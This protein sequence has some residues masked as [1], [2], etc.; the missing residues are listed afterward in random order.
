MLDFCPFDFKK[1]D[2]ENLA[3]ELTFPNNWDWERVKTKTIVGEEKLFFINENDHRRDKHF[4]EDSTNTQIILLENGKRGGKNGFKIFCEFLEYKKEKMKKG[5]SPENGT[6]SS[7][8]ESMDMENTGGYRDF[9]GANASNFQAEE[10]FKSDGPVLLEHVKINGIDTFVDED[11]DEVMYAMPCCP[12][13]HNRLP[14]GWD[15]AED[16]GAVSLMAKTGGG[17]TTLL[18]SMMHNH[19]AAFRNPGSVN[20]KKIYITSAHRENDPTDTYYS[21]MYNLAEK[22]CQDYGDCPDPTQKA[23][24]IPPVFLNVQYNGHTMIIGIYD[25]AGEN[26]ELP[27][28]QNNTQLKMLLDKMFAD[29]YLFD[30]EDMNI[31]LPKEK[32]EIRRKNFEDCRMLDISQQGL[33]QKENSQREITARELLFEQQEVKEA[34]KKVMRG[35]RIYDNNHGMR[36]QYHCLDKMKE[37]YFLGVIIKCDLLENTEEIGGEPGYSVLFDRS[38]P[39]DMTDIGLMTARSDLVEE[40]INKFQLLGD[41]NLQDFRVDYGEMEED[42][43]P[44]E[45]NGV[46]WHCISALGCDAILNEKL[47]GKYEPIRVAEPLLTC[48]LKRIADNGWLE[49]E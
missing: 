40:M 8:K 10:G 28:P 37:M 36:Q 34:K 30:P 21:E 15:I 6:S 39:D 12:H 25:N 18:Y 1:I 31:M 33:L 17:K 23:T 29:I 32:E 7:E 44:T 41:R 49:G 35:L 45:H 38:K 9:F 4:R 46:S 42:G 13:C 20:G 48:I 24:W 2:T 5:S 43:T 3:Y 47:L 14:I 26:L 19:W 16:F 11:G 27:N 22:M